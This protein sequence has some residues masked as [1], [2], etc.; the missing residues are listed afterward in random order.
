MTTTFRQAEVS[1]DTLESGILAP[2]SAEPMS[3]DIPVRS[4]IF[5]TQD[6]MGIVS[7]IWESDPGS[8]RWEFTERG[9]VIHVISGS[10]TVTEDGASGVTLTAGSTAYF[11]LGWKGIWTVH[12]P[13]RKVFVVYQRR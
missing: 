9:E 10:M 2:P 8:A 5:F 4:K 12:E 6:D 7:G 13:L 1:A 11:P 3:G